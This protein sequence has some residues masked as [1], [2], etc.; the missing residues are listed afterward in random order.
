MSFNLAEI[1]KYLR[2]LIESLYALPYI[3]GFIVGAVIAILTVIK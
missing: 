2:A 3:I 1:K